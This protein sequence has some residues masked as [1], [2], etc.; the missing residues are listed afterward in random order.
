MSQFDFESGIQSLRLLTTEFAALSESD[1]SLENLLHLLKQVKQF[2]NIANELNATCEKVN[3]IISRKIETALD[4]FKR[5][6]SDY[7]K[8][9]NG[10]VDKKWADQ[11]EKEERETPAPMPQ[12]AI[13]ILKRGEPLPTRSVMT[14]VLA[15]EGSKYTVPAVIIQNR[16]H[17]RNYPGKLCYEI[18]EK[19]F[20]FALNGFV[21]NATTHNYHYN[22]KEMHK[23]CVEDNR[24]GPEAKLDPRSSRF[25]VPDHSLKPGCPKDQRTICNYNFLPASES[26]L[27][28]NN[29][30]YYLRI[31]NRGTLDAD[32]SI[33]NDK[34]IRHLHAYLASMVIPLLLCFEQRS[35]LSD[36][37]KNT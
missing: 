14:Q 8:V 17:A 23:K 1:G 26:D 20:Y 28:N 27:D 32:V 30:M 24:A 35:K 5:I 4:E 21:I 10:S 3:S 37:N 7:E 12:P 11:V 19:R 29:A 9:K 33:A 6:S 22:A 15:F 36:R 31:G 16:Q 34:H 13:S 18:N 25:Y 2:S